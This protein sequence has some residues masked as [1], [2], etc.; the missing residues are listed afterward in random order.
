MYNQGEIKGFWPKNCNLRPSSK[1][2]MNVTQRPAPYLPY[3]TAPGPSAQMIGLFSVFTYTWQEDV[4]KIP[5]VPGAPQ[6][7]SPAQE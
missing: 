3:G 5:Q 6:N 2:F 7:I 1:L 4:E